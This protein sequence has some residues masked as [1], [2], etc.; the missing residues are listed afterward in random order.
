MDA[1]ETD[2]PSIVGEECHIVAQSQD[3]PRG[4]S[5]LTPEQRDTYGNLILLCNV[6]HKIVDDQPNTYTVEALR[7]LKTKHEA[8]VRSNL[9][10]DG[11]KQADEEM[12]AG[13]IGEWATR[14]R[15]NEWRNWASSLT[16]HGQPSLSSEMKSALEDIGPWILGR[17]WSHR[18]PQL[19]AALTNF[20]L[21]AQDLRSVFDEH[22]VKRGDDEWHTEKFYKISDWDQA[23]HK[24]L[25]KQFHQ[26]VALVQDLA[27]ELTRGANYVCDKTRECVLRS[28]RI[29]EGVL[30]IDSGPYMDM[31]VRT[32][33][34]EYRGEERTNQPYRGL[35]A[36]REDR[37]G[38][39]YCFGE[40]PPQ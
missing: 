18:C 16:Y 28:Y 2:D 23:R 19:E 7:D 20:R 32:H 3:G 34:V 8:W 26:H 4:K 11:A 38:R 15:I 13:Y 9:A 31:T 35:A 17:V 39:D 10:Y 12:Y 14:M 27:L 40:P 33:R 1:S 37:F 22:A 21:I 30:L 6:H 25:S 5:D 24:Q 36:F 29:N